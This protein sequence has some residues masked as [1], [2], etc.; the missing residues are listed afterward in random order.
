MTLTGRSALKTKKKRLIISSDDENDC[1]SH[2]SIELKYNR[3]SLSIKEDEVNK[4][5]CICTPFFQ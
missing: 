5:L 4:V 1:W 2:E 3:P